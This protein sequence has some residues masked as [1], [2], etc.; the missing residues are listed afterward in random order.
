MRA[1]IAS[2]S[3]MISPPPAR[4][5]APSTPPPP[6]S[7]ALAAFTI[8]STGTRVMSPSI[9]TI[10]RPV[11]LIHSISIYYN[12]L[13]SSWQSEGGR[14]HEEYFRRHV[15]GRSGGDRP[16]RRRHLLHAARR[17]HGA[18]G[19]DR[20]DPHCPDR[21]YAFRRSSRLPD[22]QHRSEEH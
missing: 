9:K 12:L 21:R 1:R 15:R 5:I 22:P 20:E 19:P 18:A 10:F 3:R 13:Q 6:A 17:A 14:P 16:G 11:G 7:A 2:S 4:W 8:A